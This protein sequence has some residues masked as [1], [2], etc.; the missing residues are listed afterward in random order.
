[1]VGKIS[2]SSFQII[3]SNGVSVPTHL[4]KIVMVE[5]PKLKDPLLAAFVV[6]NKPIPWQ[7]NLTDYRLVST[8]DCTDIWSVEIQ[9]SLPI[10]GGYV[11]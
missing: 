6:P 7:H 3:G 5:D 8:F 10:R 11:P 2:P 9:V 4:F 1:M